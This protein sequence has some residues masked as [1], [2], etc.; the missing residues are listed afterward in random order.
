MAKKYD[1]IVIGGGPAGYVAAI[2]AAQLG[3]KTACVEKW[4]SPE[5]TPSLGGT[6]LN[7][8]C[9]PSKALLESSHHFAYA[10]DGFSQHGI[11][12][13]GV[14]IDVAQMINR[15]DDIVKQLTGGIAQLFKA[16]KIDW[17]QG[18]G[19]LFP[20]R[21]VKV[22]D[23]DGK[24]S[25]YQADN[26]ILASGSTPID[27]GA[28]PL[29]GKR[30]IDSAGALALTEVPKRLGVIGGGVIGL[31]MASVWSRLGAEVVI[32]EAMDSFLAGADAAIARDALRSFTKQGLDV[33]L[34]AR[35]LSTTTS[36]KDVK[37]TYSNTEGEHNE[38]FDYLLVAVGRAPYTANLVDPSVNLVMDGS[39]VHVDGNCATNI[40]GVWAIGDLVRGPMLAHKGSEEGVAVADRIA[41]K[42][43][44]VDYDLVPFVIYTS[45]EIA[46]VGKTEQACK[47]EGLDIKVGTFPFA[48]SGRAR[49]M[50]ATEGQ[51]K[52][53]A[54][55]K[56]D[57]VL[58]VHILGA[59]ASELIHEAVVAMS[60]G[61]SSEDIARIMHAHPT[62]AESVKEAALSVHK[63]AIHMMNKK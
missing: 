53:I 42:Y 31:E 48:A 9:I 33:R 50:D 62:L 37:V 16:N 23:H 45:P 11:K 43:A 21:V 32:F 41:G 59:N 17:L 10:K 57:R 6:C 58:G 7:V 38:T 4:L 15:K 27:I 44:F 39:R 1:V 35:V 36:K 2:R 20:E 13:G 19:T 52:I 8:G 63:E 22:K 51:V 55:A 14:G 46:W 56:Y 30:I 60:F 49:A 47:Q 29:D 12:V 28:A 54:D 18:E 5:G 34:G 25:E 61:S 3:L 40:P 26:V 24:V